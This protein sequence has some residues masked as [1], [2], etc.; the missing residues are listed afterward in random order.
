MNTKH[1]HL[2]FFKVEGFPDNSEHSPLNVDGTT[3]EVAGISADPKFNAYNENKYIGKVDRLAI[4]DA[5]GAS[6]N[7]VEIGVSGNLN[8]GTGFS[9]I[10]TIK[11]HTGPR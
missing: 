8:D 9:G 4:E 3:L 5:I 10:A 7:E 11:A 1:H 2:S 6:G